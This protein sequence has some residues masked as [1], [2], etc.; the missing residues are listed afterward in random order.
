MNAKEMN[1]LAA[2]YGG[3]LN[4]CAFEPVSAGKSSFILALQRASAFKG[5]TKLV[6]LVKEDFDEATLPPFLDR[7]VLVRAASWNTKTLLEAIVR[8]GQ[9]FD[10][11][12]FAWADSPLLDAELAEA[13]FTRLGRYA[14]DYAY[15]DGW[16]AGLAPE[17]LLPKTALALRKLNADEELPV[18]RGSLFA[19]LQK[20]IN[21]FDIETEL[22]PVDLRPHR[23]TLAADSKRNLLLVRRCFELPWRGFQSAEELALKNPR[24]LRTLPAFFPIMVTNACPQSCPHCPH[25]E[26][27]GAG[28]QREGE[29]FMPLETFDAIIEKIA[30]WVGDAVID[31][32]L[33]GEIALHPQKLLLIESVLRRPPLSL[34]LE[35]CGVGWKDE[36]LDAVAGLLTQSAPRKG[37]ALSWI[38]SMDALQGERSAASGG[39]GPATAQ[40]FARKVQTRFHPNAYVQILRRLGN[41]ED[42]EAFYRHWTSQGANVIV[43]KYDDFC[44]ALPALRAGDVRPLR[45]Q[46]CWHIM[47]DMPILIDGAAV[48][49][50]ETIALDDDEKRRLT[51][52]NM[53]NEEPDAVW[54]NGQALY[55]SHCRGDYSPLCGRCDE[56]YTYNF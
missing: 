26:G 2:L 42:V 43:Q 35:T 13:L 16:P 22:S 24:L 46:P 49:C 28:R 38:V 33:W 41:E 21:S 29:A 55:D 20:D 48:S 6:L 18:E 53:A 32:S 50:R 19:V 27:L 51:W 7:L 54:R 37:Q 3:D 23:L 25:G 39:E 14:A 15:A 1:A 5:V 9:G 31:I 36:D 52:G 17:L 47:R 4:E 45:R 30:R 12:Y 56:Y 8:E 11:V 34:V 40:E 10:L 44:G